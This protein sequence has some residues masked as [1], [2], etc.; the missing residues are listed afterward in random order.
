MDNVTEEVMA[1]K[2]TVLR[3]G[4]PEKAQSMYNCDWFKLYVLNS[5]RHSILMVFIGS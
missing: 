3:A 4:G 5:M 1:S 2:V